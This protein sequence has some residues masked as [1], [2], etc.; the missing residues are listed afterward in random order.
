LVGL[1]AAG[2]RLGAE[3]R[4]VQVGLHHPLQQQR[5]KDQAA[6]LEGRPLL[7]GRLIPVGLGPPLRLGTGAGQ[8]GGRRVPRSPRCPPA[9]HGAGSHAAPG[10]RRRPGR[11][12]PRAKPSGPCRFPRSPG[13]EAARRCGPARIRR[14]PP[15]GPAWS[16]CAVSRAPVRGP[17]RLPSTASRSSR[18]RA[19]R[20]APKLPRAAVPARSDHSSA[21]P[22]FNRCW[23]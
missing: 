12:P 8:E 15:A 4:L 23:G 11:R 22:G 3:H 14:P 21:R 5:P 17:P 16:R 13:R 9:G 2:R 7:V 18:S 19:R 10:P 20:T 1:A 6:H